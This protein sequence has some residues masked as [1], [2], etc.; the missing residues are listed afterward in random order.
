MRR[1]KY[2]LV[3]VALRV[4]CSA[5]G[6]QPDVTSVAPAARRCAVM[7]AG[8][9]A[10][11]GKAKETI[12][13]LAPGII[14]DNRDAVARTVRKAEVGRI[15]VVPESAMTGKLVQDDAAVASD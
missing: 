13:S 15:H 11:P 6:V 3:V 2:L 14:Q 7:P 9:G 10:D 12:G 8:T 1:R 5:K 4:V